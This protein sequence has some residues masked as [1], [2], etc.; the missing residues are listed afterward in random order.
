MPQHHDVILLEHA[1][2]VCVVV[3]LL[4]LGLARS[5]AA[6]PLRVALLPILVHTSSGEAAYLSAGLAD[7]LTARLET[8]GRITVVR[9]AGDTPATTRPDAAVEAARPSGAEYVVFGSFTQFGEGASL[10]V[11]CARIGDDEEP[12]MRRVFVQ[13]GSLG[14]VIPKLGDLA[15]KIERYLELPEPEP[16]TV[17]AKDA[18]P[19]PADAELVELR[20]RVETL[21]RAV[22]LGTDVGRTAEAPSDA[23]VEAA[24][25]VPN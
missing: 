4:G 21:E 22:F 17:E 5:A 1:R 2:S 19:T 11:Q 14:E 20:E 15:D 16:V 6:E 13:A 10:D 3:A 9:I 18:T 23:D 8:S 25:A 7:M 24:G 12:E